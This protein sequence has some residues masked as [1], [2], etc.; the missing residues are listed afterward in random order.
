MLKQVQ[1]DICCD[2]SFT[3]QFAVGKGN[4]L[5]DLTMKFEKAIWMIR[6]LSSSLIGLNSFDPDPEINSG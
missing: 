2:F 6:E 1:H 4:E 5:L 3:T